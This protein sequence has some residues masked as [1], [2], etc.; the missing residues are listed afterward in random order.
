VITLP[1]IAFVAT[2]LFFAAVPVVLFALMLET[3]AERASKAPVATE[4]ETAPI[5]LR[6]PFR[7]AV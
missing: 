6:F 2:A 5:T 1:L 7:T 4:V 3:C